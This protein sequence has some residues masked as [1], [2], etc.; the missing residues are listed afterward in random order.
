MYT[1]PPKIPPDPSHAGTAV[2]RKSS[3][4][5]NDKIAKI[6]HVMVPNRCEYSEI[7]I[8]A[9]DSDASWIISDAESV[10]MRNDIVVNDELPESS[11]NSNQMNIFNIKKQNS[12]AGAAASIVKPSRSAHIDLAT[13]SVDDLTDKSRQ[14]LPTSTDN[15]RK[16]SSFNPFKL[17]AGI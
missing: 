17:D 12:Y 9:L 2:K 15:D 1:S 6:S 13:L 14:I 11:E 4:Q 7:I 10:S 8:E 3:P 5:L 16:L